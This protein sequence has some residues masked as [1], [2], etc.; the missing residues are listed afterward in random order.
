MAISPD[1]PE[2][3]ARLVREKALPFPVLSDPD[4]RVARAY[5]VARGPA[6][7]IKPATFVIRRDGRI[8]W[9]HVLGPSGPRPTPAEVLRAVSRA[10]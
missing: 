8:G 4:R 6:G 1:S 10:R 9:H 5:G 7:R 2:L 3:S